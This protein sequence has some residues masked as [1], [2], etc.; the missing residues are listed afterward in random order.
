M[1]TEKKKNSMEVPQ[2]VKELPHDPIISLLIP[3]LEA[4]S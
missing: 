1:D 3:E 2:K 4:E